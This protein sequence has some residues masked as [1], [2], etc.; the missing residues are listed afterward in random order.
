MTPLP[1][2]TNWARNH[3]YAAGRY[4]LPAT[5][6]AL[7]AMVRRE[8]RVKALGTRHAFNAIADT[9]A[10]GVQVSVEGLGD[11]IVI[12]GA[13]RAVTAPAGLRYGEL[14]PR[15][16][17]AGWALRNLASLPH[18]SIA[19]AIATATHGS[20]DRCGN[21]ATAVV[22]LEFVDGHGE[23]V[24]YLRGDP[25]FAGVVVAL[26]ALGI[27]IRVTLELV[28]TYAV[29]QWVFEDLPWPSS[30]AEF[31]AV[32]GAGESVSLFTD[33]VGERVRQVWVKRHLPAAAIK[34]GAGG[35]ESESALR[36]ELPGA[37]PAAGPRHPLPG[38][39]AVNCTEQLGRPGP[40]FERLPHFR[41]EFTPSSGEELQS[42]YFV[43]RADAVAAISALRAL[44]PRFAPVLHVAE[45][46]TVAADE[47][48]LSPCHERAGVG[49][50]F[51][52]KKEPAAVR[53][54]LP[55]IEAVLAPFAPRP[56]WGKLFVAGAETLAARCPRM[57]AFRA[58]VAR[59]DPA[60]RF[61]ND[62]LARHVLG[63]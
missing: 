14:A 57:A 59:H 44:A 7:Q 9:A 34:A 30:A 53:R 49:F 6:E 36:I 2:R 19:G 24:R 22:G 50:H 12:D 58:L 32:F 38:H 55:E 23:R 43:A 51:T 28:P 27:V 60:G 8:P 21:L 33:W 48:W 61:R 39:D 1:G 16:H 18:L 42:E 63:E 29:A 54:L 45:I 46:R 52:W 26:G 17:A 41:L 3:T 25:G 31:D 20:G 37:R 11:E 47:L 35:S 56:H 15:L 4:L 5:V 13:Q 40:W 62:W 10:D